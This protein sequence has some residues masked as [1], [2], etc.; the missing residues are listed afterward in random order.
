MNLTEREL[1][2]VKRERTGE[3]REREKE[4]EK[5]NAVINATGGKAL[6][7]EIVTVCPQI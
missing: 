2:P 3:E 1:F 5:L 7:G 4:G 6:S